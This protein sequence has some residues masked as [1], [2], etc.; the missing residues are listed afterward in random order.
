MRAA[1][2]LPGEEPLM[3]M[4]LLHLYVN[5]NDD[6]DDDNDVYQVRLYTQKV[7]ESE[8]SG[9]RP[10]PQRWISMDV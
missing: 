1:S 2:Q 8:C 6:E 5:L 7:L 3:W 9:F 4:M 10:R